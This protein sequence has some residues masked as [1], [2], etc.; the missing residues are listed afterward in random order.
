MAEFV[1]CADCR[2]EFDEPTKRRFHAQA[3]ACAECGPRVSLVDDAGNF[4]ETDDPIRA[5]ASHLRNGQIVAVKG[6]G[7]YHLAVDATNETAVAEL[8]RRGRT[9]LL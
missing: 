6:L 9:D 4:A 2:R 7:G 1:M 3:N 5:A 8:R